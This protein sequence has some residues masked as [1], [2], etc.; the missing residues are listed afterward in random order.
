[1]QYRGMYIS[2]RQNHNSRC[3]RRKYLVV[4]SVR[5]TLGIQNSGPVVGFE[6]QLGVDINLDFDVLSGLLDRVCRDSNRGESSS[7]ELS[8]SRWAPG[9][10]Y[11]S[12]FQGE[13][14]SEDRIL[15]GS[16]TIDLTERKRLVDGRALITEGENRSLGVNS[17]ADGK[18][19]SDTRGSGSGGRK[20]RNRNAR[21]ILELRSEFGVQG[22]CGFL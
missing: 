9:S 10:N 14:S 1:M 4:L 2:S 13:F 5:L 17:N 15:D 21:H 8:D 18:T 19:S 22:S 12:S 11:A 16:V 6:V 20:I 7:D 3:G